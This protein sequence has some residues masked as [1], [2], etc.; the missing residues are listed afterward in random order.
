MIFRLRGLRPTTLPALAI[1]AGLTAAL[2][3]WASAASGPPVAAVAFCAAT[4]LLWIGGLRAIALWRR[5]GGHT[6]R[7]NAGDPPALSHHTL[8]IALLYCVADD[9]DLDAVAASMRQDIPVDTVILDDSREQA[10]RARIDAFA[11]SRGCRVIRRAERMGYKAG[12][13]NH[14]LAVLRGD[15]DAYLI[16]DSDVV[17]P[18]H[19][20]RT[21]AAELGDPSVAV[22]QALPAARA[23]RTWFAGYF[24]PLLATHVG[25]TRRGR[26]AHGIVAFL[27]RGALVRAS[28]LDDVGGIPEVVA[29]DLALTV[30]LRSH[31]WRLVN[32]DV[33]FAEDYPVDYRS[34]RTQMRKTAEG[35]VEFLRRPRG[36]R[37][38]G[39]RER[40]DVLLETALIPLAA[41]AGV[42]ALVSG[43]ALAAH[44]APPPMWAV[45]AT[46]LG[47]VAPLLPE[48]LRRARAQRIAA[49][50]V[51]VVI[52]GALYAST[53]AVVLAAVVR[54]LAGRRAVF[55]IT[56]KTTARP[57][58]RAWIA[59]L[60]P[61]LVVVPAI[62][63]AVL[64]AAGS[65]V[66]A[67]GPL[68]LALVFSAP[69]LRVPRVPRA[70]RAARV[71]RTLPVARVPWALG[72]HR[73]GRRA[74]QSP[75]RWG[76]SGPKW[77][78]ERTL[79]PRRRTFAPVP[80]HTG[81]GVGAPT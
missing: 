7:A 74:S 77:A 57:G 16:C 29:E 43:A 41:L 24:G 68:L 1:W 26:D 65:P 53:M 3:A 78:G 14:G 27:G 31:G 59:L 21:C 56:P 6:P 66:V 12:N 22:A 32:V 35:A 10:S 70:A 37:T 45:V 72:R 80:A 73:A 75:A 5:S 19:F 55:W 76:R 39:L 48:A 33:S 71:P 11:A 54:A 13:L 62:M 4:T 2:L 60:V 20:V 79:A 61:E 63:L 25:V 17:L 51:F 67:V 64:F 9:A 81:S 38:L 36:L 28:A 69:M 18:P 58:A 47:A 8:R 40:G 52:G 50:I 34:F 44:G 46:T 30:A 15:Y 23:G 42:V 49:G